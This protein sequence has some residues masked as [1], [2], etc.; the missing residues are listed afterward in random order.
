MKDL[1][2][3]EHP[4]KME[5]EKNATGEEE[6]KEETRKVQIACLGGSISPFHKSKGL[7]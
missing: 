2:A 3:A 1:E 7:I 4:R 6:K 5:K